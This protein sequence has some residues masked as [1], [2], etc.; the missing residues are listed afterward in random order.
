MTGSEVRLSW[1]HGSTIFEN[2]QSENVRSE[3]LSCLLGCIVPGGS[4]LRIV[5][6]KVSYLPPASPETRTLEDLAGGAGYGS[7]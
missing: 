3:S 6:T 7:S 5:A 2:K 4:T 1:R